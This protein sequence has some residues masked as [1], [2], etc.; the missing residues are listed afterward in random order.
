MLKNRQKLNALNIFFSNMAK[1]HY[2][3]IAFAKMIEILTKKFEILIEIFEILRKIFIFW[4]KNYYNLARNLRLTLNL[5][6]FDILI[7]I[8]FCEVHQNLSKYLTKFQSK[9]LR[10][11][12][13]Y[14]RNMTKL[15][16]ICPKSLRNLNKIFV[17]QK[18]SKFDH[19]IEILTKI[20]EKFVTNFRY[21][22]ENCTLT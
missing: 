1:N 21:F 19:N 20:L 10:L 13:R 2:D 16:Q 6:D 15:F 11:W 18:L 7:S 22:D 5:W 14:L 4:Q 12:Q 8:E 17:Q 3:V 9:S